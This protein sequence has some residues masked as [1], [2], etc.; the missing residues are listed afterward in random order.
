[1]TSSLSAVAE[2]ADRGWAVEVAA[3]VF[4]RMTLSL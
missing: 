2:A 4:S 3:V 1:L